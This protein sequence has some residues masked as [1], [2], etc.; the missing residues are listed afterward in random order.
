MA[1]RGSAENDRAATV[2]VIRALVAT[3]TVDL[4]LVLTH[5]TTTPLVS[6]AVA[7]RPRPGHPVGH[8]TRVALAEL[9]DR[10]AYLDD[11]IA[12]LDELLVPLVAAHAAGLLATFGVGADGSAILLAVADDDGTVG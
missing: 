7:L 2:E 11:Q 12:R 1:S 6:E 3:A 8:S 5:R 10:V 4:G 9:G